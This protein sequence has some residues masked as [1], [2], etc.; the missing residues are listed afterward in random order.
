M[1]L[2]SVDGRLD[3]VVLGPMDAQA[4]ARASHCEIIR[5]AL[6]RTLAEPALQ[7][8]LRARG[9]QS[10][11]VTCPEGW[12]GADINKNVFSA[13]DQADLAILDLSARPGESGPSANVMYELGLVHALGLPYLMLHR[14]SEKLPFYLHQ[15]QA[16]QLAAD[17]YPKAAELR[18][19]LRLKLA[20][21]LDP[22]GVSSFETNP[23]S[24]YYGDA[25]VID[26]SAAMGLAVGYFQNFVYRVLVTPNYL[27]AA[28]ARYDELVVLMPGDLK[29]DAFTDIERLRG[30]ARAHSSQALDNPTL[31]ASDESG[32]VRK[33]S[34]HTLGR[35][36]FDVPTAAYALRQSPRYVR[37]LPATGAANAA[38][39]AALHRAEQRLLQQFAQSLEYLLRRA[40]EL[41]GLARASIRLAPIPTTAAELAAVFPEAPAGGADGAGDAPP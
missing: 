13:I 22:L 35:S 36:I 2:G 10:F 28:R 17:G 16:I 41:H 25:A 5:D 14:R 1:K 7:A 33:L 31:A 6:D 38:Q 11:R 8:L 32:D 24:S 18:R 34:V 29:G 26:I 39:T 4:G 40:Q 9:F 3:V 23:I 30:L 20:A 21:F 15:L 19:A 12:H 27:R 37:R